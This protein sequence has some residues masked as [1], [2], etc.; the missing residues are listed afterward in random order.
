MYSSYGTQH[1]NVSDVD[2]RFIARI[3]FIQKISPVPDEFGP[4]SKSFL[5]DGGKQFRKNDDAICEHNQKIFL[6][7]EC[8]GEGSGGVEHAS[9]LCERE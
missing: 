8:F 5:C 6:R 9:P 4:N 7:C 2:K 1:V 3:C